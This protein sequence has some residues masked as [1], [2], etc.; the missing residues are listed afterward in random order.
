MTTDANEV[1]REIHDR[2]PVILLPE[3]FGAWLETREQDLARVQELLVP[4]PDGLLEAYPV[5]TR[6]NSP[7]TDDA[8]CQE[9]LVT[10][11][12][13]RGLELFDLE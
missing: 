10:A 1:M 6:V 11:T 3:S 9:R 2:M 7:R 4:L 5:S 8:G 12:S 13:D